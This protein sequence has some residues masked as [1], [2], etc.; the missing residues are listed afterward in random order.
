MRLVSRIPLR[1]QP[2]WTAVSE[3]VP[4]GYQQRL[5]RL[6]GSLPAGPRADRERHEPISE[7]RVR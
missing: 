3:G 1:W 5:A 2:A 6:A 4:V 7:L